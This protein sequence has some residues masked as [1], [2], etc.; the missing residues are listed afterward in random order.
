[1]GVH[2]LLLRRCRAIVTQPEMN[3]QLPHGIGT[4][5]GEIRSTGKGLS[6]LIKRN[7]AGA[8]ASRPLWWKE[9]RR[10]AKKQESC[11]SRRGC[12]FVG[13]DE[14]IKPRRSSTSPQSAAVTRKQRYA[15]RLKARAERL[16]ER[17][18]GKGHRE[19]E[20]ILFERPLRPLFCGRGCPA[21]QANHTHYPCRLYLK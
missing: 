18:P 11:I 19:S 4:G 16:G 10:K 14:K 13:R 15:S 1:M 17:G 21:C 3:E 9:D 20:S 8:G 2:F 12:S 5:R 7:R 6:I